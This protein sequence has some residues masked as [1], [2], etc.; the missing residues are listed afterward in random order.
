M[1]YR[2]RE[3]SGLNLYLWKRR[4]E[5]EEIYIYYHRDIF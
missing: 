3:E 1:E 2:G 5:Y 4:G